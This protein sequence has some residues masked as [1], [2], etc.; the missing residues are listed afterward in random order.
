[1]PKDISQSVCCMDLS[2]QLV[3]ILNKLW[4]NFELE[5]VFK[6]ILNLKTKLFMM[7]M[8]T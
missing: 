2:H 4:I 5:I 1:M 7:T 8:I 3:F 6:T